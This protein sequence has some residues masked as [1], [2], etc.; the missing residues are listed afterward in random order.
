ML[1][2]LSG[3]IS[4]TVSLL[5]TLALY[6][7]AIAGGVSVADY[8]AFSSA[9]GM[10]SAAFMSVAGIA[11]SLASVKPTLEMARPIMEAV[12]EAADDKEI[13]TDIR[14]SIELSNVSFRYDEAMPWVL[15]NLSLKIKAGEYIAIVGSTGCGKS[16]LLRVLLGFETPQKGYIHY[17]RR[18]I[19]RVD[20]KSLRRKIGVVMQ[21]GKLFWGD[22]YSNIVVSAPH[23]TLNDAWEAAEIASVADDIRA[24]PMQWKFRNK[25][26]N[27][28][29]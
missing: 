20:L 7:F 17:D 12:P 19:T 1:L 24:M 16:T 26:W 10:V 15:D 11:S 9:Y 18:D 29:D 25:K 6:S 5:G 27:R 13:V 2:K 4:L 22:I 8:Y 3:T 28:S 23:L 14:G 21:D